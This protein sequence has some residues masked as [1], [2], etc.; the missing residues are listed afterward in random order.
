MSNAF[1][2]TIPTL[3]VAQVIHEVLKTQP[4]VSF[5]AIQ[6]RMLSEDS[7][8]TSLEDI[9]QKLQ[10]LGLIE[11]TDYKPA[12]SDR[13][14]PPNYYKWTSKGREAYR[15]LVEELAHYNIR[16]R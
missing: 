3:K 15:H 12:K 10:K 8:K 13:G 5:K 4:A 11:K 6:A 2:Q 14:R 1:P 7:A 16:L 9:L